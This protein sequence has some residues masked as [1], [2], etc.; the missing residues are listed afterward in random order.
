MV[1]ALLLTL[2]VGLSLGAL[3]GGGAVLSLP[4][5]VFVA[6]I[7]VTEAVPMSIALVGSA[8]L[9]GALL[10][11]KAGNFHKRAAVVFVLGGMP[12]AYGGSFLTHL[13]SADLL[14]LVFAGIMAI[15]GVAM[16]SSAGSGARVRSCKPFRCLVIGATVGVITGFLGAGGGFLI[17][18]ALVLFGGVDAKKA[19]GTSLAIIAVNSVGGL[20]GQAHHIAL[21]WG[22]MTAFIGFALV[23]MLVGLRISQRARSEKLRPAFGLFVI[24]VA[25]A[26][27]GLTAFGGSLVVGA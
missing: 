5:F 18:P 4:V 26:I 9:V 27:V 21:P 6:G 3:G 15:A 19:V 11:I 17:V 25:L 12:A 8:S 23:G 22:I 10:H 16:L 2:A 7:P 24:A 20:V 13:V 14:L 1:S